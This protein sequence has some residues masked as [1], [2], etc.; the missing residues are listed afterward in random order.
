MADWASRIS[1]REKPLLEMQ[2]SSPAV[3]SN[4]T[5]ASIRQLV[6]DQEQNLPPDVV[7]VSADLHT[8]YVA[9]KK[10]EDDAPLAAML[11]DKALL[12]KIRAIALD[13]DQVIAAESATLTRSPLQQLPTDQVVATSVP[14]ARAKFPAL[15]DGQ[16][17]STP[18]D[19]ASDRRRKNRF[20]AA[21]VS[22]KPPWTLSVLLLVV[23]IFLVSPWMLPAIALSF[24]L[25]TVVACLA[26]G[27]EHV[28]RLMRGVFDW[29][30]TRRP[31][32]AARIRARIGAVT[33]RVTRIM[34]M[35]PGRRRND[36]AGLVIAMGGDPDGNP[37]ADPFDRLA[38][39]ATRH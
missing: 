18:D 32:K 24:G 28:S 10:S 35:L 3:E 36:M 16:E 38:E 5:L 39:S 31:R 7:P 25:I 17:L 23:A 14:S 2:S 12:K 22:F 27:V 15:S 13:K 26:L 30:A 34:N 4:A 8:L 21:V 11:D 20:V 1:T 9:P 33:G 6:E 19:K 29:Y 37:I